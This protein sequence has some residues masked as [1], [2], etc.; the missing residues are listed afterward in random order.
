MHVG[1]HGM[2][3]C[4]D[5]IAAT[6]PARPEEWRNLAK[7]LTEIGYDLNVK[8]RATQAMDKRRRANSRQVTG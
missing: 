3:H 4:S 1:Q 2:A 6:R 8:K 5:V 7:E